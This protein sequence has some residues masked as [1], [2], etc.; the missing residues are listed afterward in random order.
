MQLVTPSIRLCPSYVEAMQE[1]QEEGIHLDFDLFE[2]HQAIVGALLGRIS[3][4]NPD[5]VPESVYW[6][7]DGDKH[8]GRI[9]IRHKLNA[10]LLMNG[11]NIGYEIR[12]SRRR[13]GNG[14][15][16]LGMAL[17]IARSIGLTKALLTCFDFNIGSWKIMEKNG[18][19]LQDIVVGDDRELMRRYWI[20]L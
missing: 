2:D 14:T 19:V 6:L 17:P 12:P 13:Q 4:D 3:P 5:R 8:V 7:V 16:M 1:Y 11:G 20:H 15:L 9:S 10:T 18:A